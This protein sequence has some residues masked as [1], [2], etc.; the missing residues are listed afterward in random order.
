MRR[1]YLRDISTIKYSPCN[2]VACPLEAL[3]I[4]PHAFGHIHIYIHVDMHIFTFFY[5]CKHN[6]HIYMYIY[7]YI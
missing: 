3:P 2:E 4:F 6:M 7:I 5:I 1:V